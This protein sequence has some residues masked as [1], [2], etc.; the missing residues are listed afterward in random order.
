M[1]YKVG[2]FIYF[3]SD[4]AIIQDNSIITNIYDDD[5][6]ILILEALTEASKEYVGKELISFAHNT[7]IHLITDKNVIKRLQKILIFK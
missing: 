7:N 1:N 2:D 4:D 5:I 6:K 3:C